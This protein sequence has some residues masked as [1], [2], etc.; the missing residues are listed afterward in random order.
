MV[1]LQIGTLPQTNWKGNIFQQ[2]SRGSALITALVGSTLCGLA[3]ATETANLNDRNVRRVGTAPQVLANVPTQSA[4]PNTPFSLTILP[5]DYFADSDSGGFRLDAVE[6]VTQTL[7][8]WLN[9]GIGEIYFFESHNIPG[10]I[11]D[12][13]VIGN[14]AYVA[15]SI[16]GL[17]IIDVSNPYAPTLA[18]SYN[19]PGGCRGLDVIGNFVYVADGSYGLQIIDIS[20]PSAPT[21]AGSYNT[22]SHARKVD[23]ISNL[24]YVADDTSGLQIIDVSDPN[25]P[26]LAGSFD[27]PGN[28]YGVRVINNFAYVADYT[29]G[30]AIIDVSNSS[31]PLLA[32][33]YITPGNANNV[34][35]VGNFA[36]VA[37]GSNGL[38]II[39]VSNPYAPTL[40]G[41]YNTPGSAQ[42][43][44]VVGDFAYVADKTFGLAIIDVSN[45]YAPILAG[46]YDTP[47]SAQGVTVVGNFVYVGDDTSGLQIFGQSLLLSGVPRSGGVGNYE[48]ELI[49]EDPDLNRASSTFILRIEG[50]PV[51]AGSISNKLIDVG[52]PFS[53]FIDQSVFPDPNSDVVYYNAKK[54]DQSDL[55]T[56]LSFSPI[57]IFSGTPQSTDTGTY[58]IQVEAF[59]GIVLDRANSTFSLTVDHFP[60]VTSPLLSHAANINSPYSFTV[61]TQTFTDQDV[62][63]TLTYSATLNDGNPLPSWLSFNPSTRVF[64][65]TPTVSDAGSHS[66]KVSAT[67]N[68]GAKASSSF[69]LVAQHFPDLINPL[70]DQLADIGLPYTYTFP[71]G[72][73][74]DL[75]GE[76]LS[77][78]ATMSD[79]SALPNW[80]GFYGATQQFLGTPLA[81]NNG[82]ISVKVIAED[83]RGGTAESQFNLTVEHFPKVA[84]ALSN[85]VV[86][87]NKPYSFTVPAQT[88]TDQDVG[89]TLTYSATLTDGSPLPSW[90][91]FNPSTRVFSGTPTVSD[92]GSLSIKVSAIDNAGAQAS[93]SFNLVAENFPSLQNPIPNQL[94]ALGLPY[95][96]AF[97][98]NTF[99][100]IEGDLLT[101]RAT[102]ADGSLLPPWLS[103]VGPK[104]EFQGTPQPSDKGIVDLK[105]MA[106]DPKGGTATSAF[107]LNVVEALSQEFATI[108]GSFVYGIPNDMISSPLGPVTHTVTLVDGSPLPAWIT[109]NP[110]TNVLTG[111]PPSSSEG[112]YNILVTADDGVQEPALGTLSLTVGPN[113]P[114]KVANPLSNEVAQ[115]GQ[116]FRLVVPD[117]T[118][119]DPNEDTLSLSATK[120]NG[121]ALPSWLT[122]SDRTL[123][124]KPGPS[125]TGHFS[126]KTLPLQVC[127]TDGD[128]EACSAFDLSV[129]GTSNAE[130]AV[131]IFGP[132]VAFGG[133]AYGWFNKRGLL[134]NPWNRKN[135]D[136]GTRTV[137]I[138]VPFNYQMKTPKSKIKLVQ[139]YEGKKMF[140]GLPAPKSL[141]KRGYLEWLKFDKPMAAGSL[142]PRWL[143][144][145]HGEN[146]LVS[147]LGPNQ[148]D[149]GC[150]TI[151]VYGS[152]EVILEEVRLK[153]GDQSEDGVELTTRRKTGND[154]S[155]GMVPLLEDEDNA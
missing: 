136:K 112:V 74:I 70:V 100:D 14:F 103:F 43:V 109:Y 59:D 73:F 39:D 4:F 80:L 128:Q 13:D 138:G 53:H 129:Q 23:V 137:T 111:I 41:S 21:L 121:R 58:N 12:V 47:G 99:I 106:E 114:P 115:V 91:S 6:K 150:Y 134:L 31:A 49:A 78:R 145:D 123:T 101:Y 133:L 52:A 15:D 2:L 45:P 55:P 54:T 5:A 108:G 34:D 8:S 27:T 9:S 25:A 117:N 148:K 3:R 119:A 7:P 87:L 22:P 102:K 126:D 147:S 11:N 131:S 56:W 36:Y 97:P 29:P 151:R 77:Y 144:Y 75:D 124:G 146:Q 35:V 33:S 122:F 93:S 155:S 66:V 86:D 116:T 127:A 28:A 120:A 44:T 85:Q 81:S 37:D 84:T 140:A 90:L 40:A 38:Q 19:T 92:A 57:G 95:L 83:P 72:T 153:V 32:G 96:Y 68:A 130:R 64:S 1:Q 30:L 142:L 26:T 107:E 48:F 17:A 113:A 110:I 60:Q 76:S 98:G 118:F 18:G 105:V 10:N 154:P 88:F 149:A 24:A 139:A 65:G 89:D 51:A 125:D 135:Y 132:V 63:D 20:N 82:Q 62:G 152:G 104:L 16:S 42:G 61:P 67:D 50:A 94:V 46:S 143:E 79:G 141:D 69:N 71:G